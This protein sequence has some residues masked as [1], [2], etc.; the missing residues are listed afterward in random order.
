MLDSKGVNTVKQFKFIIENRKYWLTEYDDPVTEYDETK[1]IRSLLEEIYLKSKNK[2]I[3]LDFTFYMG[4]SCVP[5][6]VHFD[7]VKRL[8]SIS[9]DKVK[10]KYYVGQMKFRT[11]YFSHKIY[12]KIN[13]ILNA[14]KEFYGSAFPDN[15]DLYNRIKEKYPNFTYT[16]DNLFSNGIVVSNLG[17]INKDIKLSIHTNTDLMAVYVDLETSKAKGQL[18]TILSLKN[19]TDAFKDPYYT[20]ERAFLSAGLSPSER[21]YHDIELVYGIVNS[22]RDIV[23]EEIDK[24]YEEEQE[25]MKIAANEK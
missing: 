6:K 8:L 13:S 18:L 4:F 21:K 15:N 7:F 24:K 11:K 20:V 5:L 12:G 17:T 22:I 9:S 16:L 2:N 14:F 25:R 23:N 3:D 10:E 1:Q 19:K